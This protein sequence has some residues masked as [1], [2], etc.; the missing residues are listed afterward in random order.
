MDFCVSLANQRQMNDFNKAKKKD[1]RDGIYF[2]LSKVV[3]AA[4]V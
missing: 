3:I 2:K 4:L 1:E